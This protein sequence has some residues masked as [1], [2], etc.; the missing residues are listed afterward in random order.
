MV[1][2]E[3]NSIEWNGCTSV[4]LLQCNCV[5]VFFFVCLCVVLSV[6]NSYV[7]G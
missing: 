5:G 1:V 2:L 3:N 6:Y 7:S 4:D